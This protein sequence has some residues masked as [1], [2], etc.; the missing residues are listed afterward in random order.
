[1]ATKAPVFDVVQ[2]IE[3]TREERVAMYLKLS[4][5]ELV[6]MLINNIDLLTRYA[7]TVVAPSDWPEKKPPPLPQWT[8]TRNNR[9]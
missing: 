8:Y 1:M 4:K 7:P 6:A 2:V 5:R 3:Q 9:A